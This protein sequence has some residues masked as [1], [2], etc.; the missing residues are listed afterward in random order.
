[1]DGRNKREL[2][3][4]EEENS[5]TLPPVLFSYEEGEKRLEEESCG[6]DA[7]TKRARRRCFESSFHLW[8]FVISACRDKKKQGKVSGGND[9]TEPVFL[10][11]FEIT[12]RAV[13]RTLHSF[14]QCMLLAC[15]RQ[16]LRPSVQSAPRRQMNTGRTNSV[17][18]RPVQTEGGRYASVRTDPGR[19]PCYRQPVVNFRRA[20][21]VIDLNEPSST[22]LQI[23]SSTSSS[24]FLSQSAHRKPGIS[25]QLSGG[26]PCSFW[27]D[28]H[29]PQGNYPFC[30]MLLFM[31]KYQLPQWHFHQPQC[32]E[33]WANVKMQ[34]HDKLGW[35]WTTGY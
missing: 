1:M 20:P 4:K 5:K 6:A 32:F 16:L 18:V 28:I 31:A 14:L 30:P 35:C 19:K 12:D 8:G 3:G 9:N 24:S 10:V 21:C 23:R 25:Q 2:R 27:T 22:R 26:S 11:T 29:V 33:R 13:S 7:S 15:W 34:T 17:V